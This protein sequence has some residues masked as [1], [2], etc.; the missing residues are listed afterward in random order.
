MNDP[1]LYER[2]VRMHDVGQYRAHHANLAAAAETGFAGSNYRMP[3]LSAAVA[4]AQV[5]KLDYLVSTVQGLHQKLRNAINDLPG[6]KFRRAPDPEGQLGIEMLM[7]LP[8]P[9]LADKLRGELE[10]Y[11]IPTRQR[12]G[13][14]AQTA[15]E[16][17]RHRQMHFGTSPEL[18]DSNPWPTEGYRDEDF[19]DLIE[20]MKTTV[21]IPIGI[22]FTADDIDHIATVLRYAWAQVFP[23]K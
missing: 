10:S 3:E 5:R 13:A 9:E 15:R 2:A 1:K 8:S 6:I 18:E 16:Y 20:M 4:L 11:Q 19:S 14:Y 23:V 7:F 12:T 17:I 21:T 22:L